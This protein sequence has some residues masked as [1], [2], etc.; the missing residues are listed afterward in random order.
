M[1]IEQQASAKVNTEGRTETV[2]VTGGTGYVAGWCIAGLLK[3]GYNVRTTIRSLAKEPAVR[4]AV[5]AEAES[6]DR[7]SVYAADLMADAGWKEAMD[8][9]DYVLHI[10]SPL[11]TAPSKD[12]NDLILPAREGTL[13][14]LRAATEAGVKRVVMTSSLAAATPVK[15]T[16]N[17]VIDESIWSD[18]EDKFLDAYRKSKVLAEMAAWQFMKEYKGPT[19]LTT[20][21]PG[22]I[23]GPVLSANSLGSVQVISRL[24]QGRVPGT[25]RLGFEIVDVRDL[26]DL[27]IRAMTAPEAAGQRFIA[28]GDFMWMAEIAGTLRSRLGAMGSKVPTRKLPDFMLRLASRFDPS[29]R[30]IVPMLGRKYR[31]SPAKAKRLLGWSSRPAA[32]TVVDTANSLIAKSAIPLT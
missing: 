6:G 15:P 24:V 10:A 17:Q 7:L 26:A 16:E 23:F 12:P 9:C 5:A 29:L 4:E 21:L 27:H 1:M 8:G 14:V 3:L 13:R 19:T 31:S 2:L 22:A 11:G 18:P 25:P 30:S 20:I 28:V 32:E